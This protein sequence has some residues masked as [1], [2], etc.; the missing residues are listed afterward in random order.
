MK[1]FNFNDFKKAIDDIDSLYE[2]G[3]KEITKFE[4]A[5]KFEMD[6]FKS[7]NCNRLVGS[8][9]VLVVLGEEIKNKVKVLEEVEKLRKEVAE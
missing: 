9:K 8:M 1:N 4:I 5:K 6:Y 2:L 3:L 7:L